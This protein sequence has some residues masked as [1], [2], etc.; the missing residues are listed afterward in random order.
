MAGINM[1]IRESGSLKFT[2]EDTMLKRISSWYVLC[3]LNQVNYLSHFAALMLIYIF[4]ATL[5]GLFDAFGIHFERLIWLTALGLEVMVIFSLVAYHC[6]K[7]KII[8]HYR[9][10]DEEWERFF[11]GVDAV[12]GEVMFLKQMDFIMLP[13]CECSLIDF[14]MPVFFAEDKFDEDHVLAKLVET[15]EIPAPSFDESFNVDIIV[16]YTDEPDLNTLVDF[17]CREYRDSHGRYEYGGYEDYLAQL[18]ME[19][20]PGWICEAEKDCTNRVLASGKPDKMI[21]LDEVIDK[22]LQ[23][24]NERFK[25][26]YLPNIRRVEIRLSKPGQEATIT[27]AKQSEESE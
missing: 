7:E 16:Y 17:V 24:K 11:L 15:V 19:F 26:A 13:K 1:V 2:K 6:L 23:L 5:A 9:S 22:Y 25:P 12:S 10:G 27:V 8:V 20:S 18:L 3:V 14:A 21:S 4:V